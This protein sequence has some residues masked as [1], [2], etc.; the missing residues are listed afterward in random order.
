MTR[1]GRRFPV[2]NFEPLVDGPPSN[3]CILLRQ[4]GAPPLK[5]VSDRDCLERFCALRK[6]DPDRV[7]AFIRDYGPL[8]GGARWRRS[9][10]GQRPSHPVRLY[11]ARAAEVWACLRVATALASGWKPVPSARIREAVALLRSAP[12][13][14]Y[15]DFARSGRRL[16]TAAQCRH[17]IEQYV[18]HWLVAGELRPEFT[19]GVRAGKPVFTLRARNITAAI[20]RCLAEKI[21]TGADVVECSWCGDE[22]EPG[23]RTPRTPRR[24]KFCARC[25]GAG[26]PLV[27]AKRDERAR[28]RKRDRKRPSL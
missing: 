9:L 5:W 17:A 2:G 18:S 4:G 23:E 12:A 11:C 16:P 24:R 21:G 6:A 25:R 14:R 27:M 22:F 10:P 13:I 20:G 8:E 3:P 26:K 7:V 15:T 19:W 28:K 1:S